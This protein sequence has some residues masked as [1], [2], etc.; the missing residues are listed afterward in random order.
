VA[1]PGQRSKVVD[2]RNPQSRAQSQSER[3]SPAGAW[4][5][6]AI[7]RVRPTFRE[8]LSTRPNSPALAPARSSTPLP[9][10]PR[11]RATMRFRAKPSIAAAAVVSNA[12]ASW[13]EACSDD[14]RMGRVLGG[15]SGRACRFAGHALGLQLK[16]SRV[17]R[18]VCET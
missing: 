16:T 11:A 15:G 4:P 3:E 8:R 7:C 5:V 2:A 14:M 18:H 17:G 1:A 13:R 9:E 6:A 10:G 12:W